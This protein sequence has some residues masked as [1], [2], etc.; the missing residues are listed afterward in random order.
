MISATEKRQL[1]A[2]SKKVTNDTW[3]QCA[4]ICFAG[5][6]IWGHWVQLDKKAP[7]TKFVFGKWTRLPTVATIKKILTTNGVLKP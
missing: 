5:R 6:S 7:T 4:H 1:L 3:D 2:L